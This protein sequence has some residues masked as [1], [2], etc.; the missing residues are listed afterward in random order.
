[1]FAS[2]Q[3]NKLL[4]GDPPKSPRATRKFSSPPPL[5]IAKTASPSRRR[6]LSLNIPII[7]GG[8]ALD[9]AALGCSSNGYTSMYSA[10]SPFGKTTLDTSKLYVSGGFANKIADEGDMPAEK[11][12]DPSAPSRQS[13]CTWLM[14]PPGAGGEPGVPARLRRPCN[15]GRAMWEPRLQRC[16]GPGDSFLPWGHV[17]GRA[18][19]RQSSR[20]PESVWLRSR[21]G[22]GHVVA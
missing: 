21:T 15:L 6:K 17:L 13:E 18:R 16:P 1:M 9:L 14:G 2:G 19:H 4:Y 12:E 7:T 5:S 3:N 20:L 8:K 10:M 11:P 22:P